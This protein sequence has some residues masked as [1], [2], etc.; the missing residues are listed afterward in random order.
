M[1]RIIRQMSKHTHTYNFF[2]SGGKGGEIVLFSK[3][4]WDDLYKQSPKVTPPPETPLLHDHIF[5][6]AK[7]KNTKQTIDKST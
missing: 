7:Y 6:R 2:L 3:I 4:N 5:L 1:E